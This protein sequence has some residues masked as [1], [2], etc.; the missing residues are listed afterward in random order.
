MAVPQDLRTLDAYI[1]VLVVSLKKVIA[2]CALTVVVFDEP[3]CITAAK[4]QEQ[5]RRDAARQATQVQ[6][7]SDLVAIPVDDNFTS[8]DIK[9][10]TD[11]QALIK[12]RPTRRRIVDEVARIVL[13]RLQEQIQRW[14]RG[15]HPGGAVIF[16]GVDP[17]GADRPISSPREPQLVGTSEEAKLLFA[18]EDPIGEGDLKLA[19]IGRR[20][21]AAS[22]AEGVARDLRLTL[23][24]TIDTDSFAIELIEEA[25]RASDAR[26]SPSNT[27]LCMRERAR[28]RGLDDD[29]DAFYLCCDISLLHNLIQQHM[30]GQSRAPSARHQ[31]CAMTLLAAGWA[32]CGCDFVGEVKPLRSDAVFD[33]IGEIVK[34]RP[35]TLEAMQAAWA[36][37][38]EGTAALHRPMR[39]L[40]AACAARLGDKPRIKKNAIQ[41]L[42]AVDEIVLKRASWTC[43]YWNSVEFKGDLEQFGFFMPFSA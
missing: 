28:K 14:E 41:N 36:G 13:Q 4:A 3:E 38:R 21:R 10:D 2:T 5:M 18:R 16:D 8:A 33:A 1:G 32:L 42:F 24:V 30:F 23:N 12:H 15:G 25:K 20:V 37:D 43:S 9:P 40:L 29:R 19:Q 35:A 39:E 34:T 6:S 17:R 27:V 11:V 26:V 22:G 31:R 7:S